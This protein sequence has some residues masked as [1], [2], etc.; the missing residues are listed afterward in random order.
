M[1]YFSG[2]T[3]YLHLLYVYHCKG[4]VPAN[5]CNKS[6]FWQGTHTCFLPLVNCIADD[7]LANFRE[8]LSEIYTFEIVVR[9]VATISS[10]PI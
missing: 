5:G 7:N 9:K 3:L 1:K 4:K 2:N 10:R 6:R 8:I